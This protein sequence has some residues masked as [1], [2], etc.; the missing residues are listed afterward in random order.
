M[1][2]EFARSRDE[3]RV[4]Q[5]LAECQLPFEDITPSHLQHFLVA[6]QETRLTG[7][8]GLEFLGTFA[9]LRSLAVGKPFRGQGIASWLTKHVEDYAHTCEIEHLY[10]LTTT[11][12]SF[13]AK[14]GY[15]IMDRNRVPTAVQETT[16][17]QSICPA[18]AVCMF[19]VLKI[20]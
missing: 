4:K 3:S 18:T 12:E 13:F 7:V 14:R 17:F 20:S 15:E 1:K 6:R 10:L 2:T 16:E 9:L 11:A 19:K 8:I 5:L